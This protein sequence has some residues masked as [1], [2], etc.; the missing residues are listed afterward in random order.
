MNRNT[1]TPS[2]HRPTL[3]TVL[4]IEDNF[5]L[6]PI[7]RN[8]LERPDQGLLDIHRASPFQVTIVATGEQAETILRNAYEHTQ[9]FDIVLLDLELPLVRGNA[10]LLDVG[11]NL[12]KL[13][14]RD[15]ALAANAVVVHS[16]FT[17]F[18]YVRE[19]VRAGVAD[20]VGKPSNPNELFGSVATAYRQSR[21]RM[22][23]QWLELQRNKRQHWIISQARN[24]VADRI[25]TSVTRGLEDVLDQTRMVTSTLK[26]QF[27]FDCD[28]D[29]DEPLC[30]ELN[31]MRERTQ[32]IAD[33]CV[34]IRPQESVEGIKIEQV[35]LTEVVEQILRE[36]R[37]G[38]VSKR[39]ALVKELASNCHIATFR[40]EAE[41]IL[42]ELLFSAIDA[43]PSGATITLALHQKRDSDATL[44]I[45]DTGPIVPS[46]GKDDE[47]S[48][49]FASKESERAWILSLVE[50]V[51]KS[52]GSSV[53][54]KGTRS[55]NTVIF[56][57]RG[58]NHD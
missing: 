21:D 51:A 18:E 14:T 19:T 49:E 3:P 23:K 17:K 55:E 58:L 37:V 56:D 29:R 9:P 8:A 15:F 32:S 46:P 33:T 43:A 50:R 27:Q 11:M 48:N 6:H 34:K 52:I 38:L 20:F 5:D 24:Q 54:I 26:D 40:E 45:S 47:W 30:R 16:G 13:A 35:N 39:I 7:I 10:P 41:A 25:L 2:S 1:P 22:T 53:S 44:E 31:A 4:C 36:F 57:A 12:L 28:R 42:H